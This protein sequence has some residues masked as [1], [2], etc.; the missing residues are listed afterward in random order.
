MGKSSNQ[1]GQALTEY[2]II[3]ALIVIVVVFIFALI[4]PLIDDFNINDLFSFNGNND[5][6]GQTPIPIPSQ[7]DANRQEG[8]GIWQI[9]LAIVIENPVISVFLAVT[10][11][12]Y[13][14]W[15]LYSIIGNWRINEQRGRSNK[16]RR[17]RRT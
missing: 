17:Q 3:L 11:F 6:H 2:A 5:N 16:N 13:F 15:M 10:L 7:K 12:C 8:G 4:N 14:V 9:L 1:K